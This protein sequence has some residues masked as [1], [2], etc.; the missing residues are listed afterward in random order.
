MQHLEV[1]ITIPIPKDSVLIKKVELEELKKVEL[2]GVYW[3][4]RDLENRTKRKSEWL[5]EHVLF[6]SR[7]RKVLDSELGGFVFYPKSKGQT[8]VF[9]ASKMAIFLDKHFQQ[10]FSD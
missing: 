1:N 6:P 9:Q 3:N 7:F 2:T 10:I 5:K 4:M 8:W